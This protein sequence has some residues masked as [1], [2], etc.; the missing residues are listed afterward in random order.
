MVDVVF[1]I[2][3][4]AAFVGGAMRLCPSLLLGV[5]V[6]LLLRGS[7]VADAVVITTVRAFFLAFCTLPVR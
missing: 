5:L 6:L 2:N 7:A 3:Q 4:Q 1:V